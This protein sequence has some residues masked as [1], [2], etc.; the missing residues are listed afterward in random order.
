[1]K[2]SIGWLED[3]RAGGLHRVRVE[4]LMHAVHV[5]DRDVSRGPVVAHAVV[6]S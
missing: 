4:V 1:M 6:I 5:D 2:S 3:E